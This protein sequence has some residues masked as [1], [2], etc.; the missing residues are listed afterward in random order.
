MKTAVLAR[1]IPS[2]RSVAELLVAVS[3]CVCA[4]LSVRFLT[5]M[6][7]EWID[8]PGGYINETHHNYYQS[9]WHWWHLQGHRFKGQGHA[10]TATNICEFDHSMAPK[11]VKGLNQNLHK[12]ILQL[13]HEMISVLKVKSSKMRVTETMEWM[14]IGEW[15]PMDGSSSKTIQLNVFVLASSHVLLGVHHCE[16]EPLIIS[17][18]K[19]S[20]VIWLGT[21]QQLAR[22][23]QCDKDLHLP[24]GVLQTSE[25]VRNLGVIIDTADVWRT[26]SCLLEGVFL[27]PAT[28]PPDQ[29]VPWRR[30]TLAVGPRVYYVTILLL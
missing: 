16:P 19:L 17:N 25:S 23:N 13:G 18:C 27:P 21:R 8:V 22:T 1:G 26:C 6:S 14:W 24:S 2:F 3:Y 11:P 29:T 10:A 15:K 20:D 5:F 9:T 12:W 30:R 4:Y 7:P 28:Y